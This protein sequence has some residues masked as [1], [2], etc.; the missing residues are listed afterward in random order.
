M[1]LLMPAV[2]A[3]AI[4]AG[5][6]FLL[7]SVAYL[8]GGGDRGRWSVPVALAGGYALGHAWLRGWVAPNGP[9]WLPSDAYDWIPYAALAAGLVGWLDAIWPGRWWTRLENRLILVGGLTWLLLNPLITGTWAPQESAGW[10]ALIAGVT[11]LSWGSLDLHA[12]RLGRAAILPVAIWVK[13][14]AICMQLCHATILMELAAILLLALAALWVVSRWAPA[15]TLERGGTPV[16]AVVVAGLILF[17]RFYGYPE[18]PAPSAV[19]LAIA[20]LFLGIDA[21]PG[22]RHRTALVRW[23]VRMIALAIPLGVALG[24]ALPEF[25]KAGLEGY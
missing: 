2:V 21:L 7:V 23:I 22:I 16:L 6:A 1:A 17:A 25:L 5:F 8:L 4:A 10:L 14:T 18:L 11:L 19:A 15:L 3:A 12:R 9:P 20:P 24:F 13:V